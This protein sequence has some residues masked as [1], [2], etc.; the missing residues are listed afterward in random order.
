MEVATGSSMADALAVQQL[1]K[2]S[3]ATVLDGFAVEH[4]NRAWPI[5]NL[6]IAANVAFDVRARQG[7][8]FLSRSCGL[9]C[10]IF[11][12]FLG[13]HGGSLGVFGVLGILVGRKGGRTANREDEDRCK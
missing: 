1:T 7:H 5:G 4:R 11:L 13:G 2:V 10:F 9:L 6:A 3:R 12:F 8:P